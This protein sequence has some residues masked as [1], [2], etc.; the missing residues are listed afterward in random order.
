[1]KE[2][3]DYYDVE[4]TYYVLASMKILEDKVE[5]DEAKL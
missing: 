4:N 3:L 2:Q 5:C 1:L